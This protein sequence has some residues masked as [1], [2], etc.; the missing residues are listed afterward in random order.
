MNNLLVI[1]ALNTIR[2]KPLHVP[3]D[4]SI[5]GWDDFY[6]AS[7]LRTPLTVV[8]QPAGAMATL[9]AE[10]LLRLTSG[11]TA[12]Q[13]LESHAAEWNCG[14][15]SAEYRLEFIA[16]QEARSQPMRAIRFYR[17][18]NRKGRHPDRRTGVACVSRQAICC[19][20]FLS[21]LKAAVPSAS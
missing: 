8:D 11:D 1:G 13:P 9:A 12:D 10:H 5:I 4:I 21:C 6:A 16:K 2:E 14:Y 3:R 18:F 19:W 7:H 20:R 15:K 17:L